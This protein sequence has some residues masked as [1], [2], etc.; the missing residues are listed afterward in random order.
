MCFGSDPSL[1]KNV[2]QGEVFMNLGPLAMNLKRPLL[3]IPKIKSLSCLYL[4]I[5]KNESSACFKKQSAENK[6]NGLLVIETFSQDF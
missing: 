6:Q 2:T 1:N 5:R 3:K 4:H